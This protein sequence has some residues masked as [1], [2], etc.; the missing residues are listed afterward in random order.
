MGKL[1]LRIQVITLKD[2][3]LSSGSKNFFLSIFQAAR[4]ICLSFIFG[5]A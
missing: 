1:E 2:P 3:F 5:Y 4:A